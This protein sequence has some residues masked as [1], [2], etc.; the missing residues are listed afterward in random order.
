MLGDVMCT[1]AQLV[2][3]WSGMGTQL[4]H[5]AP[6]PPYTCPSRGSTGDAVLLPSGHPWP[7]QGESGVNS[8]QVSAQ[9]CLWVCLHVLVMP[10]AP[11]AAALVDDAP[12]STWSR[13]D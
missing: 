11:K 1:M 12:V 4:S 2:S 8:L 10:R 6:A 3:S 5:H 9:P 13:S 7:L